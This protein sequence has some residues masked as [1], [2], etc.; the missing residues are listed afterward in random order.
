MTL[1]YVFLINICTLGRI[2]LN[3]TE[4]FEPLAANFLGLLLGHVLCKIVWDV[5]WARLLVF[6][7]VEVSFWVSL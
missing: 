5:R 7:P 3:R 1:F 4:S 2:R 6:W